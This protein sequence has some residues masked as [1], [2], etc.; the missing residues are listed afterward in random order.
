MT[1]TASSNAASEPSRPP[2]SAL[3]ELL[4]YV[5]PYR[6]LVAAWLGFLAL[7]SAATLSLPVAVRLMIDRGFAGDDPSG[8]DRWFL[9]MLAVAT[10][11]AIATAGR[12]Y[13]VSL[14][15]ERVVADLRERL[16]RH[17]LTLDMAFFERTR[18]GE[19]VSRLSAD[20]EIL[21]SVVGST[22]SVALRSSLTFAG[23]AVMLAITSPRLA[24]LAAIGIPL[25]ILP[26]MLYGRRV[27]KLSRDSQDRVADANARASETLGAMHTVQSYA[28]EAHEGQ[29]FGAAVQRAIA[30]ARRRIRTQA[31]LTAAVILLMFGAVTAVLWLGAREVIAGTLSAG[32]LIQFVFYAMI[33]GGSIA[34]LTEV[35]AELQRAAG[36][37]GR[38]ADLLHETPTIVAPSAPQVLPA[39]ARGALEFDHVTFHYPSRPEVAALED[40]SLRVRPG[41][42][43][44]LVGPSGAGK[45]TV[46]QLLLRFHDP[47]DGCIRIDGIDLRALDPRA[48]RDQLALVPQDPVLFGADAAENIRYGRLD[49]D[50]DAVAE[51]ARNA[52]AHEFLAAL[53]QAYGTYLGERGVRL[54]GGQQ[55]RLAIARAVLKD[56]PVLL[57][58]EATSALDAQSEHAIQQALERLMQHRTTLVIA[59]R[60]ATVRSADRIV[61][62][63]RGRIVAEGKHEQLIAQGGLYAELARLQFHH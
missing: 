42:R 63:D 30:S 23:S 36:G 51:A 35:W 47:D 22:V 38:I 19:L 2:L 7:S 24:G 59:H 11:L 32:T 45:S 50:D 41:E 6:H 58:D 16:F 14:L 39:R 10:L 40:F 21:R 25:A 61:V 54:S 17:L 62:L 60:L 56:A 3:R 57:L 31:G 52:E 18:S 49:A 28:R 9:G 15:G 5:R 34:A 1:E 37:M 20:T 12:F 44:A 53:P 29:R 43:V 8:I 26:I 4:P 13:F 27:Q 33:G 48:L 55:Q 46:L